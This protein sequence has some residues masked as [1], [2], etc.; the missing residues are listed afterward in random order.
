MCTKCLDKEQCHEI[1]PSTFSSFYRIFYNSNKFLYAIEFS[2]QCEACITCLFAA[3][4]K[5]LKSLSAYFLWFDRKQ[6]DGA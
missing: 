1:L 6:C 2:G 4:C 3:A 5:N